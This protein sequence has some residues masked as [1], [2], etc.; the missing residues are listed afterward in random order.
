M[1]ERTL[2]G[3]EGSF[4]RV[5]RLFE[6]EWKN[7]ATEYRYP[8]AQVNIL[9]DCPLS[10][11]QSQITTEQGITTKIVALSYGISDHARIQISFMPSRGRWP[12]PN[13]S[14]VNIARATLAGMGIPNTHPVVMTWRDHKTAMASG[15]ATLSKGSISAAVR[16]VEGVQGSWTLAAISSQS[17]PDDQ[18]LLGALEDRVVLLDH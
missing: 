1:I 17:Q 18:A 13:D 4:C 7:E 12:N 9:N 11:E 6:P 15:L 8:A 10:V 14:L 2:S 5:R 3:I 16:V